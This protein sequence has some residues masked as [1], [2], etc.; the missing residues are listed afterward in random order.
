MITVEKNENINKFIL[1]TSTAKIKQYFILDQILY[2]Y[3]KISI[4]D[5]LTYLFG[6]Y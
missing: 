5:T 6:V 3:P 2:I 1:V 4:T